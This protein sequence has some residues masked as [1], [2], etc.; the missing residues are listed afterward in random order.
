MS[1]KGV[2]VVFDHDIHN[3]DIDGIVK[4]FQAFRFVAAVT[5]DIATAT[6][7]GPRELARI[8]VRQQILDVLYPKRKK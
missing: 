8:E 1:Y 3:D 5:P 7:E 6:D 2:Y 4:A